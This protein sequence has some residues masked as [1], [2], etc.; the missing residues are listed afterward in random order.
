MYKY[1]KTL[2][3]GNTKERFCELTSN[4]LNYAGRYSEQ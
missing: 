2:E 4:A 3:R 1:I